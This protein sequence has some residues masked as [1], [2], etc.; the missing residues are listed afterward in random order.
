[1]KLHHDEHNMI[2]IRLPQGIWHYDPNTL[3][4]K[5]GGFG[6]VF[7]GSGN[8]YE[9]LAVKKLHIS[10]SEAAHR[11]LRIA[12][13]LAFRQMEHVMPVLDAGQ[14][15][16]SDSYFVIMPRAERSLQDEL[17]RVKK[18][19]EVETIGILEQIV[20]GLQEVAHIV[21]RDLKPAN[22]LY[23][24]T[25]WK[26]ADFGISR[27]VEESTSLNT[28]K[29]C[30]TPTYAAPEQWLLERATHATDIYA[31]GCIAY[32]L[33]TGY[34]PFSGPSSEDIR[35]QHLRA[36]PP[37]LNFVQPRFRMLLVS[38]LRKPPQGRPTLERVTQ[39]LGKVRNDN[40]TMPTGKGFQSLA[41]AGAIDAEVSARAD[42]DRI[43]K[44]KI[45]RQREELAE[46]GLRI[47]R[48][49][50]E[51]FYERSKNAA[52]TIK[53]TDNLPNLPHLSEDIF[54]AR[55]GS[56]SIEIKLFNPMHGSLIEKDAFNHSSWNVAI[57][58]TVI[59]SQGHPNPYKWGAN[60][61]YASMESGSEFRWWEVPYYSLS[62]R[63]GAIPF[64][65]HAVT[66]IRDADLAASV[67]S[68]TIAFAA[69]P[70]TIDDEDSD[71]FCDRWADILARAYHGQLRMPSH[72][73]L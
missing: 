62:P 23:H 50:A 35:E 7:T 31:L 47:L 67:I 40:S 57:G 16:N 29:E 38:M 8:G 2:E 44:E 58:A 39:L 46:N 52:L 59:V 49:L 18:L 12:E 26:I 48:K 65:P 10:A 66:N 33:L 21:H 22:I 3:L 73:P 6:S 14:D 71:D 42:V 63:K 11:E 4:G 25:K 70:R 55:L 37:P 45:Q 32:A 36:E 56:A 54:S 27:F 72:L 1:M 30:W 9:M 17:D 68:H 19:S 41:Q 64:E 15:I 43:A 53:R 61:W 28:L 20:L 51:L 69:K 13:D 5:P 34:P 24:D 60:L